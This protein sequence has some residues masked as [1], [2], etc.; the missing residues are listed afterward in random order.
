MIKILLIIIFVC[1]MSLNLKANELE[2]KGKGTFS[3]KICNKMKD[4]ERKSTI[5]LAKKNAWESFT[6]TFNQAKIKMYKKVEKDFIDNLDT[7]ITDINI[8]DSASNVDLKTC[9]ILVRI[10][11]NE[12]V[13]NDKLSE[14][15]A[16][17]SVE[18]GEG[19]LIS[20]IFVGRQITSSKSFDEKRVQMQ[21]VEETANTHKTTTG[22]SSEKKVA[23]EKHEILA[24]TDFDAS[25]NRVL[26]EN[27]FEVSDYADVLSECGGESLSNIKAEFAKS[28]EMSPAVR[29]K[30]IDGAKKCDVR[31][32]S[33]GYMNVSVPDKDPVSGNDRVFVSVN[34]M[35][36]DITKKIPRR[37]ASVG[38]VQYS[39]LGPDHNTARRNALQKAATEGAKII[40]DQL[41]SK[42]IK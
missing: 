3:G 41:N 26:T 12:V 42:D 15:S 39:G 5:S 33:T 28:D 9:D 24:T 30:A 8:I 10:K 13:V 25:F 38:P 29:K 22:G 20:F 35:V 16:I 14:K 34:G 2:F 19:S 23:I 32:F 17:G 1:S 6:S 11:I 7:F 31:Y 40:A 21:S 36:W 4:K 37:V 27:G 18:S